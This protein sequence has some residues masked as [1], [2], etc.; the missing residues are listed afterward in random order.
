[1]NTNL[2]L[3]SVI[4]LIM[5]VFVGVMVLYFTYYFTNRIFRKKGIIAEKNNIAFGIFMS[6]ILLSVG[7]VVSSA[8]SPSMSL[9][10]IL[11]KSAVSRLVLF[12]DFCMYFLLFIAISLFVSFLIILVS[13]KFYTF[14]TTKIEE[15]QEISENNIQI[16]LITGTIIIVISIFAKDSM[17]MIIES[18]IP[19]P[20]IGVIN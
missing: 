5:A 10:Q 3:L 16:A 1:M 12:L 20:T 18:L 6:A 17:A 14:L 15:F 7:I 19:Y 2:L 13:I 11:Q 8:Y 4:H 9:L